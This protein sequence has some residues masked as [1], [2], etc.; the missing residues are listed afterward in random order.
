MFVTIV[1]PDGVGKT[2]LAD[3]VVSAGR[4]RAL[5]FHFCPTRAQPL[6]PFVHLGDEPVPPMPPAEGSRALGALRLGRSFLRFWWAYLVHIRPAKADGNLVVAD[7]WGYG[8]QASPRAVRFYGPSWLARL[9]VALIPKPDI[10]FNLTGTPEMI[11]ARKADLE[12]HVIA[13]E[14]RGWGSLDPA[15]RVD[16]DASPSLEDLTERLLRELGDAGWSR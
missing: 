1:G 2:S 13:Q 15:R 16:V 3:R 8:Y 11:H 7:R 6:R 9:A 10:I 4:G 12:P 5:Y 14:L